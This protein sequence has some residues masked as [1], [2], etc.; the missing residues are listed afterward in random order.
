MANIHIAQDR[1]AEFC[2]RRQ[3]RWLAFFGS[4][5]RDDFG[6]ESDVD[7]VVEFD[8]GAQVGLIA[9]AG[10]QRELSEMLHRPVDLVT[11]EGL[12]PLIRQSVLD[13]AVVMYAAPDEPWNPATLEL[14]SPL[15][16]V[17]RAPAL[18]VLPG[19]IRHDDGCARRIAQAD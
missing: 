8:S 13:S 4:V 12:K 19:R 16:P 11:R 2:R 6:P 9:Y 3:I 18:F 15:L 17:V 7:V 1:L 14:C 5:L 10:A